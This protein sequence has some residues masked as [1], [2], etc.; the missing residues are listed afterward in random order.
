MQIIQFAAQLK[1]GQGLCIIGAVIDTP[2]LGRG[3][4]LS[5]LAYQQIHDWNAIIA[6]N[7]REMGIISF[8]KAVFASH[9]EEGILSLIQTAGL[10][11]LQ[12]NCVLASWPFSWVVNPEARVRL[13]K[14]IQI[15]AIFEKVFK[16]IR[17]DLRLRL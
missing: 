5:R 8:A 1:A 15:C 16:S 9:R 11:A 12:P 14:T 10:G 13:I 6:N 17:L 2:N 4:Y 3:S 7:L